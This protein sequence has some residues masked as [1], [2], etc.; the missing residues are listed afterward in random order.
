M[1]LGGELDFSFFLLFSCQEFFLCMDGM[2]CWV[3]G[4]NC[5]YLGNPCDGLV[6]E[7]IRNSPGMAS[8]VLICVT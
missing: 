5:V 7:A 3:G 2:N 6:A 4:W 8:E 1:I